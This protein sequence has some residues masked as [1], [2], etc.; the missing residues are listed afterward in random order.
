M[1]TLPKAIPI[2]MMQIQQLQ[3]SLQLTP[4][5][6]PVED[7]NSSNTSSSI[8]SALLDIK[9]MLVESGKKTLIVT[10]RDKT[11]NSSAYIELIIE[12]S[13]LRLIH[14]TS[15]NKTE[16][17]YC[18]ETKTLK[19]GNLPCNLGED[20]DKFIVSIKKISTM[21]LENK[22]DVIGKDNA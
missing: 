19:I 20:L 15:V 9:S 3:G 13:G 22:V 11:P 1:N 6:N 18:F 16:T 7:T 5:T 10:T 8:E 12:E 2:D 21:I 17:D 14:A 4:S